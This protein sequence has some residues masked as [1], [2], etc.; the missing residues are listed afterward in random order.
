[1]S[2]SIHN[3]L[4][5]GTVEVIVKEDL[6]QK[7]RGK[8]KLRVKLGIDPSGADLHIGHM[9]VVRKLRE[10][11]QL[12]HHIILLF[13][14]FTGTIGD[15]TG[16]LETRKPKTQKELEANAKHYVSQVSSLLDMKKVE[17]VW[18]ADWLSKLT[19]ADVVKLCS[20][21]TVP[22]MLQRDMFQE[23]LQKG[24]DLYLHELL[25]PLM[26]GYDS[27][28][29]KA[30]V[31]LGGTDQTFNLLAGRVLQRAYGQA[32][33]NILTV[34]ILEGL[35]GHLKMGKSEDNY[36]GVKDAPADM[37][38]KTMSIP[39]SLIFRYFE[40]ATDVSGEDLGKISH[41][42]KSGANPRD[43]KMRLARELVTLYH[44]TRHAK[45]AE[46]QFVDVFQKKSLPDEIPEKRFKEK[47][48][49]ILDLLH[50][51]GL[52]SSKGEARRL[53]EGGGVRL[54]SE[55]VSDVNLV[56]TLTAKGILVQA[57]KRRFLRV[58]S[59]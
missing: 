18:N 12:G 31:E 34:P 21:F 37:Y 50:Q 3:L 28:A 6:E 24:L 40:L 53:I 4:N 47:K 59:S 1:M 44:G 9:V 57:G 45:E 27:V 8:K 7:L 16:K 48:I 46:G 19:F 33:Q 26:Q 13:G 42:L 35:D 17:V 38:G 11:Q 56:I 41:D 23:R 25:Y 2:D 54:D 29:I 30:D 10:F 55:R 49:G 5:R 32:P 14:N 51:S 43:L 20:Q 15:P 58:K 52:S 36:I 22:Q 39:D